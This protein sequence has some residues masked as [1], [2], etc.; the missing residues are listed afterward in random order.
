V[1][2]HGITSLY[3]EIDL[4]GKFFEREEMETSRSV[5]ASVILATDDVQAVA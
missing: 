1:G 5:S 3:R 2:F 4:V